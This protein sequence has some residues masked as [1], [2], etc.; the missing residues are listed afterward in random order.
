MRF[1]GDI[2]FRRTIVA[3]GVLAAAT[4]VLHGLGTGRSFNSFLEP[5]YEQELYGVAD[6]GPD[7]D[8]PSLARTVLGGVAFAPDGDVWSAECTFGFG[9]TRFHRFDSQTNSP[10][11][12]GT[13]TL[14]PE[15]TV[16]TSGG[17]G[18]T[19]H[20][21]GLHIYS[22]SA[23]GVFQL[24]VA[25]GVVTGTFPQSAAK[26]GNALGITVD[27]RPGHHV[28]YVGAACHPTLPRDPRPAARR[29]VQ[30]S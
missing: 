2:R 8:D 28:V 17:C 13:A 22:N 10:T 6:L 21:D 11:V 14:H 12:N 1:M 4:A 20:P 7:P 16:D 18:L 26:P 23:V 27:P 25:T 30:D 19:N 24:D 15:T 3:A 29:P 9:G 5:G